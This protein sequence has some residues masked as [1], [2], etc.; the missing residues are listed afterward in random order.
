M[1]FPE[2]S[3]RLPA[4]VGELTGDGAGRRLSPEERM[5]LVIRLA[6][7]NVARGTGG[8]FGA[9]VFDMAQCTLIAPGVNMVVPTK[10]SVLHAEVVALV[11]AQQVL[12]HFDLSAT[13][14][15]CELVSS[16]EPCAM[17]LGAVTWSGVKRLVCGARDSDARQIGFDEGAKPQGWVRELARRGIEVVQDVC[18]EDAVAVMRVYIQSGGEVYNPQRGR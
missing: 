1:T 6:S 8:P 13:G 2:F 17:C 11:L 18:R 4:W 15:D 7:E 10:S 14:R 9:A 12:G 3:F 16:T 5:R